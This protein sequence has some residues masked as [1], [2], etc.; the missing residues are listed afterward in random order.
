MKKIRTLLLLL[1]SISFLT[2]T[3]RT[4]YAQGIYPDEY[5]VPG[6]VSAAKILQNQK[7]AE[8]VDIMMKEGHVSLYEP[9]TKEE[10]IARLGENGVQPGF[11]Y[12]VGNPRAWSGQSCFIYAWGVY[13]TLYGD[14]PG[15]TSHSDKVAGTIRYEYFRGYDTLRALGVRKQCPVYMRVTGHSVIILTYDEKGAWILQGNYKTSS[16]LI[17]LTYYTWEA[18]S[19]SLLKNGKRD[20]E[21]IWQ[22][23]TAYIA[24]RYGWLPGPAPTMIQ[25]DD[26]PIDMMEGET[27]VLRA[28]ILPVE[29]TEGR[30]IW[31]S[32]NPSVVFVDKTTGVITA[33]AGGGAVITAQIE[34]TSI[35]ASVTVTVSGTPANITDVE[36]H[37]LYNK[38]TGEHF[39]TANAGEK[40]ALVKL[41][42]QYEGIGWIAP[43]F[44]TSPVYRLYN[45][46]GGEHHYTMNAK[47]RDALIAAHWNYEGIGW[48]SDDEL[49][50]PLFREYNPHA[51]ANNHNYTANAKEHEA[52]LELGWLDEGIGWYAVSQ[53]TEEP[54]T[55]NEGEN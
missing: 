18:F 29:S 42:W 10:H 53:K 33:N 20:I 50:V 15:N 39:Y 32:S 21:Q 11:T 41:G 23:K 1:I 3:I 48:Y 49:T 12:N 5:L 45:K 9:S 38:R 28:S 8:A 7:L 37:R 54:E 40:D 51:R 6:A 36:M 13:Y 44:S 55:Q 31:T 30:I 14:H 46:N 25:M 26:T 52:L 27:H 24:D 34:G 16:G 19:Y 22:P 43:S 4:A 35:K 2:C 17:A 47:E